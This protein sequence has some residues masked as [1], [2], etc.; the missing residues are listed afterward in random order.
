MLSACGGSKVIKDAEPFVVTQPIAFAS[1][2]LLSGT[3]NWVI[4]RDG[5]GTW[6]TKADWD[7]YLLHI[8]NLSDEPIRVTN[9][10]VFDSLGARIELG[11]SKHHLIENSEATENRYEERGLTVTPGANSEALAIAGGVALATGALVTS[12]ALMQ[13]AGVAGATAGGVLIFA[14]FVIAG[15]IM[16]GMSDDQ[17]RKEIELRQS[18]LPVVLQQ[19]EGRNLHAFFPITP[20]PQRLVI[21]YVDFQGEHNLAIDT[22]VVLNGLHL[23][24]SD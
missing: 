8:Q 11:G 16:Y 23:E 9:I 17:V 2:E 4:V 24:N 12:V 22:K 10:V 20:S 6:A 15:G 14:P 13:S 7:E 5:P 3:L 19:G 1:D 21:T 18:L